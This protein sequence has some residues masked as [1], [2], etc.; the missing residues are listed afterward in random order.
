MTS[1]VQKKKM[2]GSRQMKSNKTFPP[3]LK[4]MEI[5]VTWSD[6]KKKK[7]ECSLKKDGELWGQKVLAFWW[8]IA[9]TECV[10]DGG[11]EQ[12]RKLA[13]SLFLCVSARRKKGEKWRWGR[14]QQ[15]DAASSRV[16]WCFISRCCSRTPRK[17]LAPLLA[18]VEPLTSFDS[19]IVFPFS[20]FF[21]FACPAASSLHIS[22]FSFPNQNDSTRLG[23]SL[24]WERERSRWFLLFIPTAN[25][26]LYE[27]AE[28]VELIGDSKEWYKNDPG[29][30]MNQADRFLMASA[31]G[32]R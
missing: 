29:G 6:K 13:S 27:T 10:P 2:E 1:D 28:R 22:V 31:L 19:V 11:G 16:C 24:E 18:D 12:T 21:P 5:L 32:K 17:Q 20:F 9:L 3:T 25:T 30:K 8:S 7:N 4:H 26:E 23:Y 15:L 14:R